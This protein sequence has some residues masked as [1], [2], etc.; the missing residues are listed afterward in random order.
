MRDDVA[1]SFTNAPRRCKTP[2]DPERRLW[3]GLRH[4]LPLEQ[5]HFR[6]QVV[7]ERAIVDLAWIATRTIVEVD[8]DQYGHDRARLRREENLG[9]GGGGLELAQI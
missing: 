9:V 6:R 5:T 7:I 1:P 4:S 2:T 8:G 3:W